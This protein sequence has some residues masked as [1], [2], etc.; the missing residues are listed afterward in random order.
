MRD[1]GSCVGE[2]AIQLS[3]SSSSS[4][5]T[6]F[7]TQS[8]VPSIQIQVSSVY[9]IIPSK[10]NH[11]ITISVTWTKTSCTFN[12]GEDPSTSISIQFNTNSTSLF[13]KN[14]KKNNKGNRS[15]KFRNSEIDIIWDLSSAKYENLGPEPVSRFYVL[16]MVDSELGLKL[17]D[18][19][20]EA[21]SRK[22]KNRVLVAKCLLVSRREN[23][24]G[25]SDVRL[26]KAKFS[27][28]GSPHEVSIR[29]GREKLGLRSPTLSVWID[30]KNVIRV[31]RLQ[32]NFRGNQTIFLDGLLIELMWDVHDWF[33]AGAGDGAGA[34]V[35]GVFMFRSRSKGVDSRLWMEADLM[36]QKDEFSLVI[37]AANCS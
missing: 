2:Y 25:N 32:W 36:N 17:G 34:S 21:V 24:L 16:I 10:S 8:S 5:S 33:F 4:S 12:F 14:K 15:F 35:G 22:F 29:F 19:A 23:F 1:M 11:L 13:R 28:N 3:D 20:D 26:M 7:H 30:R 37:C 27:E 9:T 6:F 31:K 18:M